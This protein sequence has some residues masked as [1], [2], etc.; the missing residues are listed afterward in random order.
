MKI[1]IQFTEEEVKSFEE[2][3][4]LL[5]KSNNINYIDL[6]LPSKTLWADKNIGA[7]KPEDYGEY[8]S[9][10]DA[11]K[12]DCPTKEQ[13]KELVEYCNWKWVTY[14]NTNGYL[15]IGKNGNSIFLPA[16][17]RGASYSGVGSYGIYWSNTLDSSTC[18]H[19][20]NFDS[21]NI[22]L[23]NICNR[24]GGFSVRTCEKVEEDNV[25]LFWD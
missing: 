18:G 14:K 7:E 8:Y 10:D 25:D 4:S 21:D 22:Y 19:L 12:Y 6:G 17:A 13:F 5:E 15:V 3:R 9:F 1:T 2:V 20:L 24:Y 23:E 11:Q 16:G